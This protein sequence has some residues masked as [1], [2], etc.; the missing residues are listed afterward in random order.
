MTQN[1][2]IHMSLRP[3]QMLNFKHYAVAGLLTLTVFGAVVGIPYAI[4]RYL[5]VRNMV[6]EVTSQRIKSRS[7]VFNKKLDEIELYRVRDYQLQQPFWLRMVQCGNVI[8][9]SADR[10][11]SEL[12]LPAIKNSEDVLNTIRT[13][14]ER[15]RRAR[16]V[17]DLDVGAGAEQFY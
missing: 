6:F 14:V 17:R 2:I 3:S 8:L 1:E 12:V 11:N 9:M 16:G 5:I 15:A 10:T 7:G 4:W 13:L